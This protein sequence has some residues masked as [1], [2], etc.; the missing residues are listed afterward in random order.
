MFQVTT[1]DLEEIAKRSIL[2]YSK[3]FFGKKV[4]LTVSTQ[5]EAEHLLKHLL[6]FNLTVVSSSIKRK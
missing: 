5:F 3:D 1:Q 2:D 4:G 6:Y